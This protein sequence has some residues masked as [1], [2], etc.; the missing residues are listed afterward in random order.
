[1]L[2]SQLLLKSLRVQKQRAG[3]V[4]KTRGSS[5]EVREMW[6]QAVTVTQNAL[7]VAR[8]RS[9]PSTTEAETEEPR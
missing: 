5:H 4:F 9:P 1:M 2:L 8:A 3:A 6:Q 7:P